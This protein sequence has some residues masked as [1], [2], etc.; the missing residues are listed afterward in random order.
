[1]GQ[2]LKGR[3]Y[4]GAANSVDGSQFVFRQL[5]TG[6]QAVTNHGLT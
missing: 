3:S 4:H 2:S 1:M 5:G 6:Q